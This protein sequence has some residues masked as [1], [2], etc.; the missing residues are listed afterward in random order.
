MK[1]LH[2]F[3][4]SMFYAVLLSII[5][6][7]LIFACFPM[8]ARAEEPSADVVTDWAGLLDWLEN[9]KDTGGTVTFGADI[10]ADD[11]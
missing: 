11:I 5:S 9:H 4:N 1:I 6:V 8:T 10:E 2:I 3:R 7:T